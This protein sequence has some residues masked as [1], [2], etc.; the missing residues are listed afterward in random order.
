[1][2]ATAST[3][4]DREFLR[5]RAHVVALAAALDRLERAGVRPDEQVRQIRDAVAILA[6]P[7][8]DRAA[9]VQLVFSDPYE[10]GWIDGFEQSRAKK[11]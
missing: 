1:M 3:V 4:L 5:L 11:D 6:T 2:A 9:R 8:V 10:E 7:G